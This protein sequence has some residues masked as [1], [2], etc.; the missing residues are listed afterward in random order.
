MKEEK[1]IENGK[2]CYRPADVLKSFLK[3]ALRL[4]DEAEKIQK[5]ID[6]GGTTQQSIIRRQ[7]DWKLNKKN[8]NKR[9]VGL[10]DDCIFPS[11]ANLTVLLEAMAGS[12]FIEHIFAEDFKSLFFA[13]S[14]ALSVKSKV[15]EDR[16]KASRAIFE[17]FV[18]ASCKLMIPQ[19]GGG[20]VHLDESR[21][22]LCNMMLEAVYNTISEIGIRGIGAFKF[23]RD[24][25][26]LQR[27]L[28]Q[29]MDRLHAWTQLFAWEASK[30]LSF[31]EDRRPALF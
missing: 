13:K 29:D 4:E 11:M 20:D 8:L 5:E 3:E 12:P 18:G 17:R 10:L 31:D 9:K 26:F 21:V 15:P 16:Y 1:T 14:K 23:G 2:A 7:E 28:Y 22:I 6:A 19:T 27:T 30:Q 24:E 25:S